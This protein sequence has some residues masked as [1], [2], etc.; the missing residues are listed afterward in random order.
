M[1]ITLKYSNDVKFSKSVKCNNANVPAVA[2]NLH[3][4][5]SPQTQLHTS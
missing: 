4:S 5:M 1:A 2:H 3:H